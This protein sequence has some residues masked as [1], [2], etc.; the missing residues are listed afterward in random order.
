MYVTKIVLYVKNTQ[1]EYNNTL[2]PLQFENK[3]VS[4]QHDF[5][6]VTRL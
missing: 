4:L 5:E 3:L 6:I 1:L 2:K